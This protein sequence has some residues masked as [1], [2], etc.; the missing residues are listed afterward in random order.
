MPHHIR[1]LQDPSA[2]NRLEVT[3]VKTPAQASQIRAALHSVGFINPS[4]LT[5]KKITKRLRMLGKP[6]KP[7]QAQ[8]SR[9]ALWCTQSKI[10]VPPF[11]TSV[12]GFLPCYSKKSSNGSYCFLGMKNPIPE[13]E[14]LPV[15]CTGSLAYSKE[16][17][18][19]RSSDALSPGPLLQVPALPLST[20]ALSLSIFY[21]K[22]N[23]FYLHFPNESH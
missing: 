4:G 11:L 21:G 13:G 2:G 17:R 22:G 6:C 14:L 18:C 19:S 23:G 16:A 8:R 15:S 7:L 12:L 5:H 3:Q 20:A 1:P 9:P 10:T